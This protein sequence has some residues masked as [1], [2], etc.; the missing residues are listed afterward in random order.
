MNRPE[1][2]I[3][4][5]V[6]EEFKTCT[7]LLFNG[8]LEVNTAQ[9]N[10]WTFYYRIGRIVWATSGNHSFRRWRRL[11]T[12]YCPKIDLDKIPLRQTDIAI[13]YWDY[14]QII[15]LYKGEKIC[16]DQVNTIVEQMIAELLFDLAQCASFSALNC[17]RNQELILDIPTILTSA[18]FS[19]KMMQELWSNWCAA[20][21]ASLLPNLA[22][23]VRRPEQLQQQLSPQVYK[24]C[25]NLIIGKHT[26]RELAVKL[27]QDLFPLSRSLL[28]YVQKGIIEL[29]EVPDLPMAIAQVEN[30]P[31]A[32]K[33]PV[34]PSPLI[35]CVDDSLLTGQILEQIFTSHGLRFISVQ[36]SVQALP[37]LI[38]NKP[39]LIFLDLIMPV[40]NGYEICAQ[41][42]RSSLF[43]NTPVIILTG[44]DGFVDRVRAK[45]VGATDFLSK[46]VAADK[47]MAAVHRYVKRNYSVEVLKLL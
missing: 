37:V 26:L 19:M 43:A 30:K 32:I 1:L 4:S 22:P 44:S 16:R 13:S 39:D 15:N 23:I 46:P 6:L 29:I 25:I 5:N 38:E 41:L 10:N 27:K 24:N 20:G 7:K 34:A 18:D 31:P 9:G 33:L 12:Q 11:L 40:A 17:D 45:V 35:A 3:P 8:K 42:R 28:P 2:L 21:L 36:D 14:Q 47:V